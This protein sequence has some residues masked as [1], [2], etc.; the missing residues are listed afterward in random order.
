M[1]KI[2]IVYWTGTGNTEAMANEILSAC[3]DKADVKLFFSDNFSKDMVDDFDRIAFG[4][5]AMGD[6]ELANV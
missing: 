6:E 1:K 3:K 5:P 4:C 2:A